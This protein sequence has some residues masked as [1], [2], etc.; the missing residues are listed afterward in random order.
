MLYYLCLLRYITVE[1]WVFFVYST[2]LFVVLYIRCSVVCF[3]FFCCVLADYSFLSSFSPRLL[4]VFVA[5]LFYFGFICSCL[6][7]L[8][9]VVFLYLCSFV[10]SVSLSVIIVLIFESAIRFHLLSY[11]RVIFFL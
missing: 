7:L 2:F 9:A 11:I 4:S 1:F 3:F 5:S 6:R 8:L 10:V